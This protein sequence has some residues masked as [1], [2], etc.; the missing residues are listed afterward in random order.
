MAPMYEIV[1][2]RRPLVIAAIVAWVYA[3]QSKP[4]LL[5]LMAYEAVSI[6]FNAVTFT[7]VDD[8]LR[9]VIAIHVGLR[10]VVI[11]GAVVA[12]AHRAEF[13]PASGAR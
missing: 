8:A 12:L 10:I 13:A 3:S 9:A 11:V 1:L 5:V 7:G 6:V 4:S 2:S